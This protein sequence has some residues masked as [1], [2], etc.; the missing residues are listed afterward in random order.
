MSKTPLKIERKNWFRNSKRKAE[1]C[2]ISL[3][4][5]WEQIGLFFPQWKDR[6]QRAEQTQRTATS[7]PNW[8]LGKQV[9]SVPGWNGLSVRKK[10]GE[11]E[12]G[13]GWKRRDIMSTP[14]FCWDRQLNWGHAGQLQDE[15]NIN[16]R[17]K[18]KLV[19]IQWSFYTSSRYKLSLGVA[20]LPMDGVIPMMAVPF[21]LKLMPCCLPKEWPK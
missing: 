10:D 21:V 11:R 13:G 17:Q 5:N 19:S 4:L 15:L 6:E 2:G 16:K 9:L 18:Q 8:P 1:K 12:V 3:K 14:V 20:G 7:F